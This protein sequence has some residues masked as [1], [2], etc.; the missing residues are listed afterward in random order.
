MPRTVEPLL[1]APLVG[2]LLVSCGD[3]RGGSAASPSPRATPVA[4]Q[5]PPEPVLVVPLELDDDAGPNSEVAAESAPPMAEE[6]VAALADSPGPGA[7]AR[8]RTQPNFVP[9]RNPQL[10]TYRPGRSKPGAPKPSR[11]REARRQKALESGEVDKLPYGKR[12]KRR[13]SKKDEK[14]SGF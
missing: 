11:N 1:L 3:V 12:L 7:G 8:P 13:N 5:A 14:D 9:Q 2:L 4:E 6:S 10:P